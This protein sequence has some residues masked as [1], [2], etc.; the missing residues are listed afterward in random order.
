MAAGVVAGLAAG[1][2]FLALL[3]TFMPASQLYETSR[4]FPDQYYYPH[5][6]VRI[7][8]VRENYAV[9]ER[10][11]FAVSLK[12]DC[13]VPEIVAVMNVKTKEI[14]WNFNATREGMIKLCSP[15]VRD[16][17]PEFHHSWNL[18]DYL[19]RLAIDEPGHYAV[20]VK[21]RDAAVQKGFTVG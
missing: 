5:P 17:P 11:D 20:V 10:V 6:L 1:V 13:A 9:G 16:G 3:A 4:A 12:D 14:L 19:E 15:F 8:G 21:H 2:G 18:R 7:D